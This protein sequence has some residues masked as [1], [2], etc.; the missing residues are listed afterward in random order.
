[1]LRA[2]S[3]RRSGQPTGRINLIPI[4]DAVFIFIFFLLMS[5]NFI[6]IFEIPSDVPI[7][8]DSEPKEDKDQLALTLKITEEG[9]TLYSGIPSK[10]LKSFGKLASGDYPTEDLHLYLVGLKKR[11][12]DES[13]IIL[14]PIVDLAYEEIVKIMDSVRILRNTDPEIFKKEKNGLDVR[15]KE[16]FSNII[17]GNIQS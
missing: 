7:L 3:K 2:P 4:L 8:S 17:F 11:H 15:V 16:L 1:M 12:L 6:K 13:T 5:A 10:A 14:E 9:L